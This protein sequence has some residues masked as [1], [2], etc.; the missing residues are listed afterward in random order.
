MDDACL[1]LH[2][3]GC[4]CPAAGPPRVYTGAGDNPHIL[5]H[6]PW[7]RDR[8]AKYGAGDRNSRFA[9]GIMWAAQN[10]KLNKRMDP[11]MSAPNGVNTRPDDPYWQS[12]KD[13]KYI[14][15]W[16]IA[17]IPRVPVTVTK[18]FDPI[19]AAQSALKTVTK[20]LGTVATAV[21]K[22]PVVGPIW[23]AAASPVTAAIHLA[24]GERFDKAALGVFKDQLSALKSVAPYATTIV[25][26][27]P[28]I[29]TGV[30]AAIAA[31]AALAEGKPITAALE[32]AVRDAI[33]GGAIA[34]AG[35]DMARKVAAGENVGKAALE[36]ARAQL[37]PEAQKAFDVGLAVVS[38]KKLQAAI[39]QAVTSLAPAELKQ[40]LDAGAHVVQTVPGLAKLASSLPSDI[41][42]Q[43]MTLASGV[44]AH[45]GVNEAQIRAM[46][47]KLTGDALR[48][49]DT[50]LK[51]QEA[52]FPW[53]RSITSESAVQNAAQSAA[54]HA[55][56]QMAAR[57]PAARAPAPREPARARAPSPATPKPREPEVV[58]T[59]RNAQNAPGWAAAGAM[60]PARVRAERAFLAANR[61]LEEDEQGRRPIGPLVAQLHALQ[62]SPRHRADAAKALHVLSVVQQWR[63]GLHAQQRAGCG[64]ATILGAAGEASIVGGIELPPSPIPVARL[65]RA[66]VRPGTY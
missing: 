7:L 60:P 44:L 39:A 40:V 14:H 17:F 8:F 45:A 2:V 18:S 3:S 25:S 6:N 22:I 54:T 31:G 55:V 30:A 11:A 66:G 37:P 47:T 28:G 35:F 63:S 53:L 57:A 9:Y 27:I 4:L 38:G 65:I 58:V 20:P 16:A 33:P 5:D 34:Q 51:S 21:S 19:G 29:G 26:F 41:A 64:A 52:H 61:A 10:S 42:R 50:A 59:A 1:A 49:F 23:K 36:T 62:R 15:D 48:G 46:R 43:G 32:A 13:R 12:S 24:E 56:Q